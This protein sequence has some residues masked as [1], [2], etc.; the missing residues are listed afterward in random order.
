MLMVLCSALRLLFSHGVVTFE[1]LF[2]F[3]HTQHIWDQGFREN[4]LKHLYYLKVITSIDTVLYQLIPS[5]SSTKTC[6]P[7]HSSFLSTK[8]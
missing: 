7:N 3:T 1:E 5:I 2:L 6:I 8:T 4:G